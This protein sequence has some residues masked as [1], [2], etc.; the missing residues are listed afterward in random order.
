MVRTVKKSGGWN[1]S[2]NL[3]SGINLFY[4]SN[5][6]KCLSCVLSP[7]SNNAYVV[8]TPVRHASGLFARNPLLGLW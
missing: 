7:R 5:I 4:S 3:M 1:E 6:H 2:E 8:E